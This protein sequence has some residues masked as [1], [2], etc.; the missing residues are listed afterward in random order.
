MSGVGEHTWQELAGKDKSVLV[1]C[2]GPHFIPSSL[3][4]DFLPSLVLRILKMRSVALSVILV[5]AAASASASED[6]KPVF[7]VRSCTR[8]HDA[9]RVTLV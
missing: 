7:K 4:F 5:V 2:T 9:I 6:S 8:V 3:V 1:F